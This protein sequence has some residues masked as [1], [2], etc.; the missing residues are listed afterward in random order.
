MYRGSRGCF[1]V[2]I[3]SNFS[4]ARWKEKKGEKGRG[5]WG[6][7]P[8]ADAYVKGCGRHFFGAETGVEVLGDSV[9][10]GNVAQRQ[11]GRCCHA[12]GVGN[13]TCA[14]APAIYTPAA[15]KMRKGARTPILAPN[16]PPPTIPT[17]KSYILRP[18]AP[19]PPF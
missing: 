13:T 2:I 5:S 1:H 4:R 14:L 17:R 11:K 6:S 12:K 3:A 16:L 9:W 19:A 8:R 7:F 18:F 15:G 10:G